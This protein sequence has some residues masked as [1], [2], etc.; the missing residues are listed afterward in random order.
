M[1]R[2]NEVIEFIEKLHELEESYKIKV[3]SEDHY[4]GLLYFDEKDGYIYEYS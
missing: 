1:S 4:V 3:I 2:T